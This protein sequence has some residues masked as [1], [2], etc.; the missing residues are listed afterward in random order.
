MKRT[1]ISSRLT[2]GGINDPPVLPLI[3]GTQLFGT[4]A[5]FEAG[6][7]KRLST[8]TAV[9]TSLPGRITL[10]VPAVPVITSPAAGTP[11]S[12]DTALS[13]TPLPGAVHRIQ[14]LGGGI[15]YLVTTASSSKYPTLPRFWP[16]NCTG[17]FCEVSVETYGGLAS[18]DAATDGTALM[19]VRDGRRTGSFSSGPQTRF[20]P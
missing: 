16:P 6:T 11:F 4:A 19:D 5:A 7:F 18:V 17:G 13:W 14:F 8:I 15:T 12:F 20:D 2:V 1:S 10:E 3:P 9:G